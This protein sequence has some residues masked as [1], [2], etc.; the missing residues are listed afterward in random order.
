MYDSGITAAQLIADLQDEVDIIT[1]IPNR[2]YVQWLN[3]LMQLLYEDVIREQY[4]VSLGNQ[5]GLDSALAQIEFDLSECEHDPN[6]DTIRYE[7][8]SEVYNGR[9]Q[10]IRSGIKGGLYDQ[11]PN[12]YYK[13][14]DKLAIYG[15]LN[16]NYSIIYVAR[17]A[18]IQVD[19]EDDVGTGNV[20]LPIEHIDLVKAKLRGEAYKV[21]NEDVL[22]AKWLND[23]N[24]L[25]EYLKAWAMS[26][27][28]EFGV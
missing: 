1:P 16:G 15:P 27:K 7:D 5:P 14:G 4:S 22:S 24:M 11:F 10:L 13:K 20:M 23:Y 17:P 9:V 2:L 28:A 21:A 25:L 3:S 12:T 26:R 6:A 18:L 8:I 19:S